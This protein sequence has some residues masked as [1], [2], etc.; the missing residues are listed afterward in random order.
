MYP[1]FPFKTKSI[2][3]SKKIPGM[4]NDTILALVLTAVLFYFS[5]SYDQPYGYG[6]NDAALHPMA[7]FLAGLVVIYSAQSYPLFATI[8]LMVVF[9]WIADVNL[10]STFR[11]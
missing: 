5:F 8:L 6:L 9:F 7:R 4:E 3:R 11:L 1:L 10:L 2:H